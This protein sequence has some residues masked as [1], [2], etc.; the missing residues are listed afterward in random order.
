MGAQGPDARDVVWTGVDVVTNDVGITEQVRALTGIAPGEAIPMNSPRLPMA[1]A[2]V[3]AVFPRP[4]VVCSAIMMEGARALY[5]VQLD[6]GQP[7][8]DARTASARPPCAAPATN[9]RFKRLVAL[10]AS[11]ARAIGERPAT[12]HS[13]E[14]VNGQGF[15]DARPDTV[16]RQRVAYFRRASGLQQEIEQAAQSCHP[17]TRADGI[18]LMNYIGQPGKAVRLALAAVNDRDARV[19]NVAMRLLSSFH[20]WIPPARTAQLMSDACAALRVETFFDRNKALMLLHDLLRSDA[21]LA[22]QVTPP[23]RADIAGI[24]L[25]SDSA[26]IGM[27]AK[28]LTAL[29]APSAA[30]ALPQ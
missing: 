27:P 29:L 13:G 9:A 1:C 7:S 25:H 30:L 6:S 28:A 12:A 18:H 26:Q 21:A 5:V 8:R 24:A 11:D 19:R 20:R 15:L 3:R 17:A 14:F 2:R 10:I 22:S 4:K 16:H 23:C